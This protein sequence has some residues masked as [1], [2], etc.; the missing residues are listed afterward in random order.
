ML[1]DETILKQKIENNNIIDF[2]NNSKDVLQYKNRLC[3][4]E[5]IYFKSKLQI[6]KSFIFYDKINCDLDS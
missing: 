4:Y 5:L 2:N 1:D 6:L 3:K